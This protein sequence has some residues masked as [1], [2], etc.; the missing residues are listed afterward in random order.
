MVG[1]PYN[2]ARNNGTGD[3][4]FLRNN[5]T[6]DALFLSNNEYNCF[7]NLTGA[8]TRKSI[9]TSKSFL[10]IVDLLIN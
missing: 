5:E 10:L 3:A 2:T 1:V 8:L 4:L 7:N 9:W 6:G